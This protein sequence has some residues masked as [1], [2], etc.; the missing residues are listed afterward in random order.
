MSD[1]WRMSDFESLTTE[2][3]TELS[4]RLCLRY[5]YRDQVAFREYFMQRVS[6]RRFLMRYT[7]IPVLQSLDQGDTLLAAGRGSGKCA[8]LLTFLYD[9][10]TGLRRH[11]RL[12][13][14][15]DP[16]VGVNEKAQVVSVPAVEVISNGVRECVE[17]VTG[18]GRRVVVTP[19]HRFLS[20]DGWKPIEAFR[21]GETVAAPMRLPEPTEPQ[22]LPPAVV[23][24]MA[25]MLA[26]G[27]LTARSIRFT[28][29]D[30]E[31]QKIARA[32][33]D[34]LG[35][36][37]H[38][39]SRGQ[40]SLV[41][42]DRL[43]PHPVRVWA[44]QVGLAW[45]RS[46]ERFIPDGILR[47]PNT[48][49]GRFLAVYW[50]CDGHVAAIGT[51]ELTIASRGLAE[52]VQHVLL[53]FGVQ[54]RLSHKPAKCGNKIFDAWR[55]TVYASS[56][57]AFAQEIPI[58]GEARRRIEAAVQRKLNPNIGYPTRSAIL[59]QLFAETWREMDAPERARAREYVR[60]MIDGAHQRDP[61]RPF[62]ERTLNPVSIAAWAAAL[63][64]DAEAA[65]A[66]SP[67][68]WWDPVESI[69]PIGLRE[70][71]D[72]SVPE[73]GCFVAADLVV[74]NSYTV[75]EPFPVQRALTRPGEET[76]ITSFRKTH[77]ADRCER[78]IDYF[79]LSRLKVYVRRIVRSPHYMI[80][81]WND[82]IIYGISVGDD[83]EARMAQGKH[84][85]AIII[86]EAHQ[87]PKRAAEKLQ[88]AQDPRG[89][90]TLMIGVP[91]G[92]VATPFRSADTEYPSFKGRR[93]HISKR[94]DPYYSQ[95]QK[96]KDI[97]MYGSEESDLFVGEVDAQWGSPTWGAWDLEAIQR[98]QIMGAVPK[99]WPAEVS[100]K[101]LK[102]GRVEIPTAYTR[103]GTPH[104][105]RGR[106]IMA[107]DVGYS[108][109]S[110]IGIFE[111][112]VSSGRW[113]WIFRGRLV[114]RMEHH[115]QAQ[116]LLE[117]EKLYRVHEIGVDSTEG[118][119]RAI[120]FELETALG[121]SRVHRIAANENVVTGYLE[122]PEEPLQ[123]VV[124]NSKLVATRELRNLFSAGMVQ[125]PEDLRVILDFNQEKE[126]KGQDQIV[127]IKTPEDVHIPDMFRV[128]AMV[129]FRN[130][131]PIPSGA[132]AAEGIE[133]EWGD[134]SMNPWA[135]PSLY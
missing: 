4:R 109:P 106:R 77:V 123:E 3:G 67:D 68:L 111:Q 36:D 5:I 129:L 40:C 135:V 6:R 42:R 103:I 128:F 107:I 37:L 45:V 96:N 127:R 57:E 17:V 124:E 46:P 29:P 69:T 21:V 92:R 13:E 33:G 99:W 66:S 73:T 102:D 16:V 25:I 27:S 63:G 39:F 90:N 20:V 2:R 35:C 97:G 125:M 8:D 81:L 118:E 41:K 28:K 32:A 132:S 117:L 75:L 95:D 11:L 122:R 61:L 105:K 71:G 54:S 19:D 126:S 56:F 74:H 15:G 110:E 23:D 116:L 24:L 121:H 86:E 51:P 78:I 48:Q 93:F 131:P 98:C 9:S 30:F 47:L 120:C 65:L 87:Y 104:L 133:C 64:L 38:V 88:G 62:K 53:R 1:G 76:L 91:D 22:G 60:Q 79:E 43:A 130:N 59:R 44:D 89:S 94:T 115:H 49:L 134:A 100:G 72:L 84:A 50:M 114:N 58:W 108:Q 55:V 18:S 52:Q 112:D 12:I 113:Q 14:P 101:D 70:V 83:P 10:R 82:H 7:F 85:S 80:Q 26:E 34:V 119:G 31:I